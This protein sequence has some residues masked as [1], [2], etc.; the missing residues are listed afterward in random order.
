MHICSFTVTWEKR[1]LG[2]VFKY[3]QGQQVPVES[4]FKTYAPNRHRFIRIVDITQTNEPIRYINYTGENVIKKTDLFMIRYG[5]PGI[6]GYGYSGVIANNLFRLI[7]KINIE[8]L[9]FYYIFETLY[10]K[11]SSLSSSTTMPALSFKT[12]DV[13]SMKYPKIKEQQKIGGFFRQLDNLITVNQ[14]RVDLLK[15][16]KKALLQKMFV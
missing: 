11:I 4:Q 15:Q 1:K 9:F 8:N 3:K 14:R 10:P 2:E 6:V 13:L 5:Q 16:E 7:P 12:L